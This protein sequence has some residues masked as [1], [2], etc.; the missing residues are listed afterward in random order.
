M[1]AVKILAVRRRIQ[2]ALPAVRSFHKAVIANLR[3]FGRMWE[4]GMI[5]SLKVRTGNYTKDIDLGA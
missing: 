3:L 4:A 2:P 1:D 5:A